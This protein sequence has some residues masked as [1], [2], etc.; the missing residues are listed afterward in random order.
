MKTSLADYAHFWGLM[1]FAISIALGTWNATC[2]LVCV[3]QSLK[4]QEHCLVCMHSQRR[5]Q[6]TEY[7]T[8]SLLSSALIRS[9]ET[10]S[11]CP[12]HESVHHTTL[13][14][15]EHYLPEPTEAAASGGLPDL[16][17]TQAILVG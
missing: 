8:T 6:A 12:A 14:L 3:L 1:P 11:R 17:G 15:S 9:F 7:L 13:R 2:V 16:E 5:Q 4:V 10:V